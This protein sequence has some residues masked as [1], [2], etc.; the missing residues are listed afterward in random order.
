M[1]K[2]I[3]QIIVDSLEGYGIP[4]LGIQLLASDADKSEV[5]VS[6]RILLSSS[7]KTSPVKAALSEEGANVPTKEALKYENNMGSAT[8][9]ETIV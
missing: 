3:M 9:E 6:L 4:L 8:P 7:M 5:C 1:K 2:T